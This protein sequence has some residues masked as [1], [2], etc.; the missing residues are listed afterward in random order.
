[1]KTLKKLFIISLISIFLNTHSIIFFNNSGEELTIKFNKSAIR[2]ENEKYIEMDFTNQEG[3]FEELEI[4]QKDHIHSLCVNLDGCS[5]DTFIRF[6]K[7][8]KTI[9]VSEFSAI[10]FHCTE[11][12]NIKKILEKIK[13]K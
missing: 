11:T 4:K 8:G 13:L 7:S 9:S 3:D 1:M 5:S 10:K 6:A 12:C 2:L